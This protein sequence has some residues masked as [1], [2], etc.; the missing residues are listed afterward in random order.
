MIILGNRKDVSEAILLPNEPWWFLPGPDENG[1]WKTPIQKVI[2][3]WIRDNNFLTHEALEKAIDK[4][5]CLIAVTVRSW[6]KGEAIPQIS[7]LQVIRNAKLD[8]GPDEDKRKRSLIACVMLARL[9]N[10]LYDLSVSL[11]GEEDAKSLL[12]DFKTL[13]MAYQSKEQIT[14]QRMLPGMLAKLGTDAEN[15]SA[16]DL[17]D[18]ERAFREHVLHPKIEYVFRKV[19]DCNSIDFITSD[20]FVSELARISWK[21]GAAEKA[22]SLIQ[23]LHEIQ[24][25]VNKT[26]LL[27]LLMIHDNTIQQLDEA[28]RA[29]PPG[30]Q[31]N[32]MMTTVRARQAVCLGDCETAFTLYVEA[33]QEARYCGGKLVK[34]ICEEL[35]ALCCF[36]YAMTCENREQRGEYWKVAKYLREWCKLTLLSP[37]FADDD[38]DAYVEKGRQFFLRLMGNPESL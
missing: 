26:R 32:Y 11:M 36:R 30:V 14:F 35:M 18:C 20:D 1:V 2:K 27:G 29:L 5:G 13:Y 12:G 10:S 7:T 31:A 16:D 4:K 24:I 28:Y 6:I 19:N 21:R 38:D 37:D 3:W 15:A 25:I 34:K 23:K 17:L 33:F 8:L 9:T 22:D